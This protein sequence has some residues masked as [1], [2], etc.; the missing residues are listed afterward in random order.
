MLLNY[1]KT[2][3][4]RSVSDEAIQGPQ[5]PTS[6]QELDRVAF[7]SRKRKNEDEAKG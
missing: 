1:N 3:F 5:V 2:A 7:G 4:A 6:R